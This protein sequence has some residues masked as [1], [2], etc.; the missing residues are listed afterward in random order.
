MLCAEL[1]AELLASFERA[2]GS[3][4]PAGT[5]ACIASAAAAAAA[6]LCGYCSV[7]VAAEALAHI[8]PT[9]SS[10]SITRPVALGG[11]QLTLRWQPV[12]SGSCRAGSSWST[13]LTLRPACA[14]SGSCLLTTAAPPSA[15]EQQLLAAFAADLGRQLGQALKELQEVR[16]RGLT[17]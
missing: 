17:G 7:E 9:A 2:G 10:I 6:L 11:G 12:S 4:A 8:F 16:R 1:C 5:A 14:A 13:P 15:A 3:G